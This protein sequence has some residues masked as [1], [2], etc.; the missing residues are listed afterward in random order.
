MTSVL[1]ANSGVN[2][3]P[4]LDHDDANSIGVTLYRSVISHDKV[5]RN[6][7]R[8]HCLSY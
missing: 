8:N 4:R 1:A 2:L 3:K 6:K 7:Q 5:R